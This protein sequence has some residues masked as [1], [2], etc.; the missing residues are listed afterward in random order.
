M[1]PFFH[2]ALRDTIMVTGVIIAALLLVVWTMQRRLMYFPIAADPSLASLGLSEEV[3][4]LT[5]DTADGLRLNGWFFPVAR[6][7]PRTTVLVFNGNAGNR[8]HRVPL[9]KA[10]VDRGQQVFL[11]DYRG[12]GGNPGMP[13]EHGLARDARAAREY[14]L[15]RHD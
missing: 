1:T 5:F 7:A 4:P 12:F 14:L 6:A 15:G 3:Q 8:A 11:F 10:L 2:D 13:T 9:A